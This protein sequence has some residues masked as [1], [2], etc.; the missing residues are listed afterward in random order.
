LITYS[1]SAA[2]AV[3]KRK[4]SNLVLHLPGFPYRC[5][6]TGKR[7]LRLKRQ[8]IDVCF[9]HC[10]FALAVCNAFTFRRLTTQRITD[11]AS[12]S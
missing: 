11:I 8:E 3:V 6:F 7:R 5:A 12:L 2:A 9:H 1:N 4:F 10:R